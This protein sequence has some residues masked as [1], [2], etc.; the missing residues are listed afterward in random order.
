M[1]LK[2]LF[3][4]VKRNTR[5][6][7]LFLCSIISSKWTERPHCA[8][9]QATTANTA[10]SLLQHHLWQPQWQQPWTGLL[11]DTSHSI[12]TI[13]FNSQNSMV[14]G[15]F[16][17]YFSVE[18]DKACEIKGLVQ[19][20]P[21]GDKCQSWVWTQAF[22]LPK[23]MKKTYYLP[24]CYSLIPSDINMLWFYVGMNALYAHP[25]KYT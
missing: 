23:Q 2:A 7:H 15:Q 4:N 17:L 8:R 10:T 14:R 1:F 12:D 9:C 13:L 19:C 11:L 20:F 25:N 6:T 18:K 16:H 3:W 5:F 24:A 22:L 21:T